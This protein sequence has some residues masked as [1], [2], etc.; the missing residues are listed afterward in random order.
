MSKEKTNGNGTTGPATPP[1]NWHKVQTD[2]PVYQAE[3]GQGGPVQGHMLGILDMP[4][5]LGKPWQAMVVRLTAPTKVVDREKNPYL[6]QVG[7]EILVPM[8]HQL[9]QHCARAASHPGAVFEVW[10]KPTGQVK[11]QAGSM[12]QFDIHVNPA[13]L[14]RA[15]TDR[16][17]AMSAQAPALAAPGA[18]G[19][20]DAADDDIPF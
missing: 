15:P 12:I 17:L 4:P 10:L 1:P 16:M 9:R 6:A 18:S 3:R 8:N 11:T 5:A 13:P 14:K 20:G 2:R 7:T 19:Q